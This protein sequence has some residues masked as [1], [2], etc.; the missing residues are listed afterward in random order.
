MKKQRTTPTKIKEGTTHYAKN[1]QRRNNA[2]RQQKLKK[3]Q[4]TMPTKIE[5]ET[6]H[7]ANNN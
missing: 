2:L 5:E 6:T 3:K 4:R 7:Y 1:N